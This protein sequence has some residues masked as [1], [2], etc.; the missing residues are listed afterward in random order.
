LLEISPKAA[1]KV[2]EYQEINS[3]NPAQMRQVLSD[4]VVMY[5]AERY[6]LVLW[7]HGTS[8]LPANVALKSFGDN[9]GTQMNIPALAEALP[10]HF[11]FVLFDACLMGAVEVAYELRDKTDYLIASPAEVISDG[12]PYDEVVPELLKPDVDLTRVAQAYFGYY[13]RLPG[14][15]RSATVSVTDTRELGRLAE[16]TKQ[17][18]AGASGNLSLLDRT[19]VQR[20]DVYTE[21]YTFDFLDF[22]NKVAP[23]ADKSLLVQQL[24]KAVLYKAS[25]E[26]FLEAYRIE[27]YCGL[28]CYIPHPGRSDLNS[29]YRTLQWS[30]DVGMSS[31]LYETAGGKSKQQQLIEQEGYPA[32]K[33]WTN[34][35]QANTQIWQ[36][37]MR[38]MQSLGNALPP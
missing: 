36:D 25:T 30:I 23:E 37:E 8:W 31:M 1:T 2:H 29:Y 18:L 11:D 14:A 32:Y 9:A 10:V 35:E 38:E 27:A 20:L 7:S 22:I 12:F 24:G 34:V 13:N 4:V 5:P 15:S 19:A 6:G 21:Q 16:L 26:Q 3:A 17:L 28:S 33:R